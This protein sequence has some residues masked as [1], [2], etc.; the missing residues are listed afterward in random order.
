MVRRKHILLP[1]GAGLAGMFGLLA[2]YAGIVSW[3]ESFE[4]ARTLLWEDR[5][6]V[7]PLIVGFGVQVG[8]YTTLRFRL[9]IPEAEASTAAPLVGAGGGLSATAM[10]AC[11]A[12]HIAD[13]LPLVGLTVAATFLAA[14]REIFMII[15]LVATGIGILVM[16]I[17]LLR[18]RRSVVSGQWALRPESEAEAA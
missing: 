18:A 9:F 6:L 1:L 16:V 17:I 10:V 5:W 14:Y 13:V 7:V 8:L 11:C 3:A 15:G 2:F 4:H 12:H